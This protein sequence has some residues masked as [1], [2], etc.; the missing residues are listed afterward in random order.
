MPTRQLDPARLEGDALARWYRRSPQEIEKEQD[1]R[2]TQRR[3][4]FFGPPQGRDA[5][6]EAEASA[7][8]FGAS[9]GVAFV[10]RRG[11]GPDDGGLFIEVGNP[12]NRKVR[13]QHEQEKGPW[14]RTEDGRPY[15]VS[16][17]RAVADGGD[18][19]LDNIEP[20]HPDKHKAKHR[21]DDDAS[22][23]GKRSSIARTFGGKVEPPAHAP[24]RS[25]GPK[26]NGLGLLGLLPNITGILSGRI[27]TDTPV[28]FWN[29]MLGYSSED[30]LPPRKLIL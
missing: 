30:D 11:A 10:D 22:R 16:H 1:L 24:K 18:T 4:A 20:M 19:T 5:E 28:H 15:D 12:E 13:R 17:I 7:E 26:L 6:P 27:R 29:D 23:W 2:A 8:R 25:G 3:D 9:P 14:P 21:D